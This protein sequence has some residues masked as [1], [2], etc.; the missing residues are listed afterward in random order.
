MPEFATACVAALVVF[1]TS[2]YALGGARRRK[3]LRELLEIRRALPPETAPTAGAASTASRAEQ[4]DALV[5]RELKALAALGDTQKRWLKAAG[6]TVLALLVAAYLA[7]ASVS[8]VSDDLEN[9]VR[10]IAASAVLLSGLV[11]VP[12]V[13]YL[14]SK[15][16]WWG[17][18]LVGIAAVLA[19]GVVSVLTALLIDGTPYYDMLMTK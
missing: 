10:Y 16:K 5:D 13:L 7:G 3:T 14:M 17:I 4:I 8:F 18:P 2:G 9:V 6:W 15:A 12:V 19:V 1:L 11:M